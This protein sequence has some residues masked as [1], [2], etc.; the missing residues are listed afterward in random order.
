MRVSF[1]NEYG[2]ELRTKDD[3]ILLFDTTDGKWYTN[4][5]KY[6]CDDYDLHEINMIQ[7]Q[8]ILEENE[9]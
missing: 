5:R 4:I 1:C 8:R 6:S 3:D 2:I 9:F 7:L